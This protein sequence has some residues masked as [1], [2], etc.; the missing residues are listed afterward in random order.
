MLL[1]NAYQVTCHTIMLCAASLAVFLPE[2]S[3]WE[4][5]GDSDNVFGSNFLK[6]DHVFG[7]RSQCFFLLIHAIFIYVSQQW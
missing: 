1:H 6:K 2:K 5:N 7:S 3:V 4:H